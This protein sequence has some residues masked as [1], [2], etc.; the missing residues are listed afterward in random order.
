VKAYCPGCGVWTDDD[1][2][3]GPWGLCCWTCRYVYQAVGELLRVS[4]RRLFDH[5]GVMLAYGYHSG[6]LAV[7][8]RA[9]PA[10]RT[11]VH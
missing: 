5:L 10:G 3:Q 4:D 6:G 9:A 2:T 7:R 8:P 11:G 1:W